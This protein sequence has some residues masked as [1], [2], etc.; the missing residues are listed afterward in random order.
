M[1]QVQPRPIRQLSTSV[2]NKIAAGEVIE[3]PASVV[4]E[5]L[6]NSV[7]AGAT[8]IDVALDNGGI[9]LIRVTDNGCGIGPDQL[10]LAVTSHAT[11]KIQ[12]ANDLFEVATFGFRGEALAS[13]AEVSQFLLRSR[14]AHDDCGYELAVNGGQRIP[15]EPTGMSVGT[16]ITVQNLFY[17]TPVRR[18]FLKTMQ[19][20]RGHILEAFTRIAL[21][22]P[23]L[24]MS[25]THN[26][27]QQ[28]DLPSTNDWSERIGTFFGPEIGS[29]LIEVNSHD[30]GIELS[31]FVVDPSV[32]RANNRMQYL[33]LNGRYI[34]DRSL[35]HALSESY[36][37]LLMTG[38]YPVAFLRMQMAADQV[39]VN[40]HPAKLE[41]RF[42]NG[43]K[44]Y[45]QL[46]STIRNRFLATDLTARAKLV[47][48]EPVPTGGSDLPVSQETQEQLSF[49]R[50]EPQRDWTANPRPATGAIPSFQPSDLPVP[51][52]EW[53]SA[54]RL[55]EE[56]QV[57][58]GEPVQRVR[59]MQ[60]Q[61]TYLVT[62]TEEG[63]LVIDQ[64]ALH[65][66]VLYEQLKSRVQNGTLETQR[67]L[68]P[69]PVTLPPAEAA[70]MLERQEL[71]RQIGMVIEPFGGDTLLISAYP[72][73]LTNHNPAEM[74]RGMVE[75]VMSDGRSLGQQD[76]VDEML[77]MY[78]CK[79]AIKAGDPLTPEEIDSLLQHRDDCQD[80]HHCPH[81]RPTALV[82]SRE[83]LDRRFKRT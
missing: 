51:A 42:Q 61:N 29:G 80:A 41:V 64:H 74:L 39:D 11:S 52:A 2:V 55:A 57:I 53:S 32:N 24:H 63:M 15:V 12:D 13:I 6:E 7:D 17:N 16:S 71:L 26:G 73:M 30:F 56:S 59:A 67:L 9:D 4:K 46:L 47:T 33:F 78:S 22:N 68:V 31:G 5:L 18:K 28:F 66:R 45:S 76:L 70:A 43:G 79:A 10:E 36:R 60:I 19:T 75:L 25:L 72:A 81:G 77:H 38:R 40:V 62:E 3:R 69:E 1:A 14:T 20:E 35:Q 44:L 65:E 54:S 21:A 8:R 50:A 82:F 49:P 34:R 83:E 48:R 23:A 27:K 58:S 37:G